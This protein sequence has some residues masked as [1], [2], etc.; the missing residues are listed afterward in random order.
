MGLA[1]VH[2]EERAGDLSVVGEGADVVFGR[3]FEGVGRDFE[4]EVGRG[5]RSGDWR[6]RERSGCHA[7]ELMKAP[8]CQYWWRGVCSHIFKYHRFF[9]EARRRM[10]YEKWFGLCTEGRSVLGMQKGSHW[11]PFC[12][13]GLSYS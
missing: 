5:L 11:L 8:A 4:R 10:D 13:C 3:G 7:R 6:R 9:S 12:G 1:F 2:A